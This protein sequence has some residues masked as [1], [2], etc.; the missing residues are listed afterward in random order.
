MKVEQ[1]IKQLENIN[2]NADIRLYF[3][4]DIW[5]D[6][7]ED[8][9]SDEFEIFTSGLDYDEPFIELFSTVDMNGNR[10][11]WSE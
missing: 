7:P 5:D 11:E 4:Y 6:H 9:T 2:P 10:Q 3:P 1:L 8:L